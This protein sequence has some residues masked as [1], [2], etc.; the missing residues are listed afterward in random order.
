ME[1]NFLTKGL[2]LW[3]ELCLKKKFLLQASK[4]DLI[5]FWILD[6]LRVKLAVR[7][8]KQLFFTTRCT[9]TVIR[10]SSFRCHKGPQD[11]KVWLKKRKQSLLTLLLQTKLD[12]ELG[13]ES[14]PLGI[15]FGTGKSGNYTRQS[16]G[17]NK[18]YKLVTSD[19]ST[20]FGNNPKR[21]SCGMVN[22]TNCCYSSVCFGFL[23]TSIS[24]PNKPQI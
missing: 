10:T 6:S 20:P 13:L 18:N 16:P 1:R 23:D 15:D 4:I 9:V 17:T 24:C 7:P 22:M 8:Y 14:Y 19:N 5:R 3:K 2:G 11:R 21:T 12:S